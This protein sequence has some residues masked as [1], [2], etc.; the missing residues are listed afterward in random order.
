MDWRIWNQ[1]FCCFK[2]ASVD[3]SFPH[4][5]NQKGLIHSHPLSLS[6]LF[7]LF[8]VD[9]RGVGG[10]MNL[11]CNSGGW[12]FVTHT[13]HCAVAKVWNQWELIRARQRSH[14]LVGQ[15]WTSNLFLLSPVIFWPVGLLPSV[16][17]T[18]LS[19]FIML[20]WSSACQGCSLMHCCFPLI[21]ECLYRL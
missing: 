2:C 12:M 8:L 19:L 3:H 18:F 13:W 14:Y 1:A 20:C 4:L 9:S 16:Y 11:R 21:L 6:C 5:S 7:L 15:K 17:S 10:R